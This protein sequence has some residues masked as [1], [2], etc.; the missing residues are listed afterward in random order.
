MKELSS[1]EDFAGLLQ[2]RKFAFLA[3]EF[4]AHPGNFLF[5]FADLLEDDFNGGLFDPRFAAARRL[6]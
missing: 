2:F 6:R 5:L 1:F 3:L 4:R